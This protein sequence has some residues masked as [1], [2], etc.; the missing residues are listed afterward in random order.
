LQKN[1]INPRLAASREHFNVL[2]LTN[3]IPR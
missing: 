3:Y 2:D 1:T